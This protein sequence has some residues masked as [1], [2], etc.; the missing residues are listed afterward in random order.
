MRRGNIKPHSKRIT[1]F[2]RSA[3]GLS[4]LLL[5]LLLCCPSLHAESDIPVSEAN[6]DTGVN[7]PAAEKQ[8]G[9]DETATTPTTIAQ[10]P[11]DDEYGDVIEKE[12]GPV[13]TAAGKKS[14]DEYGDVTTEET[15]AAEAPQIADPIKP[16]NVAMY[17]FNDKLYFWMWKPAA[18]GYKYAVP[19]EVRGIIGNFYE[20]LKAPIRIF[21]NLLQGEPG[22]A[23]IE[24]AN[25][26][27]NS[28]LG[29]GGFK[30]CAKECFGINGRYA[31]FGQTLGKY[32]VGFG[33]YLVLPFLGPSSVRDGIGSLVDWSLRPTTYLSPDFFSVE[34]LGLYTHER[35]NTTSF[36]LG[37]YETLKDAAVDPYVAMR[38]VYIQ[39]RKNLI[40]KK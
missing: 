32:G 13:P 18:T 20:N 29:V 27:I 19:E 16:W 4:L 7:V 12:T 23:G 2:L 38:D 36:H 8:A 21:N 25:L 35:I 31:D 17:H 40:E 11:S 34:S 10:K 9:E 39:Y 28:T 37:E 3:S 5:L 15:G 1:I 30:N 22:Y 24:L 26:F 14:S 6:I 33:F